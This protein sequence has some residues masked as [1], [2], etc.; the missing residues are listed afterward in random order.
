ML[1]DFQD[2]AKLKLFYERAELHAGVTNELMS[3]I[4]SGKH[5][6]VNRKTNIL[7]LLKR[8]YQKTNSCEYAVGKCLCWKRTIRMQRSEPQ[9]GSHKLVPKLSSSKSVLA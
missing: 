8:E 7:F 5:I 4:R 6:Y 3:R 2:E 9:S 1:Q